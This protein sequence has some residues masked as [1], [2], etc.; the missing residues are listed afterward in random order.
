M[1]IFGMIWILLILICMIRPKM[2][3][4]VFLTLASSVF[5]CSN[6][7]VF[8]DIGVGPQII[9]SA[10]FVG[11]ITVTRADFRL[12]IRKPVAGVQVGVWAIFAVVMLSSIL[13]R[14]GGRSVLRILQLFIYILCF[15]CMY[16][17]G[18]SI[19][20]DFT[21]KAM[22]C[23]TIFLLV[24]G[25]V[26]FLITSGIIPRLQIM[27]TLFYNDNLSDVVYYTR[28]NYFRIL[29]T[30]MEPSY[31][32]GFIVGA[33]YY[34]LMFREKRK[35][36]ILLLGV[37]LLEIVLT[38]SSTAYGAFLVIGVVFLAWSREGRLKLFILAAGLVG[39]AVMYLFFYDVLDSVIFSKMQSGSGVARFYAN[40]AAKRTFAQAPLYGVGYKTARASSLIYTIM[41]ELGVI[42]LVAYIWTNLQITKP[43]WLKKH[44]KM[45]NNEYCAI[46][47]AIL[48]VVVEQ[49]VAVPDLDICTYWMWMNLLAL[50]YVGNRKKSLT[51]MEG[52]S[53][54]SWKSIK[55]ISSGGRDLSP[56]RQL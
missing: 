28:N 36:N 14:T 10:A 45:Y 47:M 19:H 4:F 17:A 5:Q 52:G 37:I 1:T 32:A 42:G 29:S 8:G 23:L 44:R 22:K 50:V 43:L 41:A 18:E 20:E 25:G 31:Y 15:L 12:R 48:T 34:F 2:D 3:G 55:Y 21:Y 35:E 39:C 53:A 38:F 56:H 26:Q 24:V 33:F 9:T 27:S 30:Y 54:V 46:C 13:N 16:R 40:E 11:W 51:A 49:A 7:F 6:V